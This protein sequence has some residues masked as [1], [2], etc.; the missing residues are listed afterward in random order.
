[1]F[2][3][4]RER[5]RT[6]LNE[7]ML[8]IGDLGFMPESQWFTR[9]ERVG[10]AR[11]RYEIVRDGTN[12]YPRRR[13]LK[14]A[15][16]VGGGPEAID[17]QLQL[18]QDADPGVRFWAAHGLLAQRTLD[19]PSRDVLR[20]M[21]GDATPSCR[22]AA[23]EALCRSAPD[24]AALQTIVDA[25]D[26]REAYAALLAANALEHIG[27]AALPALDRLQSRPARAS[28][29]NAPN[30]SKMVRGWVDVIVQ[31]V[32]DRLEASTER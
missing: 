23:A 2:D 27:E 21:L 26:H 25:V 18:A 19:Q 13:L 5:L 31:R 22:I 20:A 6:V 28:N 7:W 3:E 14:A 16:L 1:A 29:D 24:P 32:I 11:P 8:E 15:E 10:D 12:V 9:F 4:T 30:Q 17:A